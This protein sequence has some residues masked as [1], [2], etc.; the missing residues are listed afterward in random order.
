MLFV[1]C[2]LFDCMTRIGD[3]IFEEEPHLPKDPVDTVVESSNDE[4]KSH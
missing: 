2:C 1:I 4:G 3:L